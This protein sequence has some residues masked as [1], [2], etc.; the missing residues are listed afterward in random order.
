MGIYLGV[1]LLVFGLLHI[2]YCS[3][4][5]NSAY[6]LNAEK[7]KDCKEFFDKNSVVKEAWKKVNK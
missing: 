6:P 1:L 5:I 2:F 7:K 3:Y 4:C